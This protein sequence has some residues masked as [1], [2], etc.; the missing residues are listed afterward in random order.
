MELKIKT[1]K[2]IRDGWAS[3][4]IIDMGVKTEEGD[5]QI[6]I[7]TM[8]RYSGKLVT[9]ASVR[10]ATPMGFTF[11]MFQDYQKTLASVKVARVNAAACEAAQ[12]AAL[13]QLP[14]VLAE[15]RKQYNL[16]EAA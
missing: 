11:I 5:M 7:T 9:I 2:D 16:A 13:E 4:T 12:K 1:A 6:A 3:E 14:E 15:V 10:F 8:K